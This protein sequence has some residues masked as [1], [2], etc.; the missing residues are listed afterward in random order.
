MIMKDLSVEGGGRC[1]NKEAAKVDESRLGYGFVE[2]E[3]RG[4]DPICVFLL[5]HCNFL[6]T[7][8]PFFCFIWIGLAGGFL[9][10]FYTIFVN[11][12]NI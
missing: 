12:V 6:D 3:P 7:L 4:Y 8:I 5:V 2:E 9:F 10:Y 11:F 1:R